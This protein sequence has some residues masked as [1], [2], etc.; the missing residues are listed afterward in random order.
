MIMKI[1]TFLSFIFILALCNSL[2][3]RPFSRQLMDSF[4]H[5]PDYTHHFI[6]FHKPTLESVQDRLEL[7]DNQQGK[8]ILR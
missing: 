1:Q 7:W 6:F 5:V 4:K 3:V 2:N 8:T